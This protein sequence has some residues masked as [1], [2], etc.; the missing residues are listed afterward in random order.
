MHAAPESA[1]RAG[2]WCW[3]RS[4]ARTERLTRRVGPV[5]A[6]GIGCVPVVSISEDEDTVIAW[7]I[8]PASGGG[9]QG[10]SL[11]PAMRK[12]WRAAGVALPRTL[13]VLWT[14]V[15][16]AVRQLPVVVPLD[17]CRRTPGFVD[18]GSLVEGPSFGLAFCVHLASVVL[19]CA[20]PEHV[21]AA[22]AVDESG[23]VKPVGGLG[24][25]IAGVTMLLPR[26]TD[27]LVSAEQ[28]DEARHAAGGRV[29]IIGVA[30]AADAIEF[31]LGDTLS[32]LLVDAGY[33][34]DRR[35]GLTASFFRLALV[36]SDTIVDWGPVARGA[37]LAI[38]RWP[39][40]GPDAGYRLAFAHAVAA[41]H[42]SNRGRV[43][44]PPS[45]WFA[46][47]PRMLR[48][49]V[50]AH[51]VQQSADTATP[52]AAEIEARAVV[53]LT[54]RIEDAALQEL[55]LR[56]A[57]GRLR[58]VTGRA[59]QA[60]DDQRT[61]AEAFAALYAEDDV[62]RPLSEWSRLA[63]AL[64]DEASLAAACALHEQLLGRGGYGGLGARYVELAMTRARLM[65]DPS[66][67]DAR[68]SGRALC[69]DRS[70]P[71]HVRWSAHRCVADDDARHALQ[72]AADG[73]DALASRYRVLLDL[74]DANTSGDVEAA[75]AAVI[76]LG[77]YDPGPVTHLRRSGASVS[78]V[79]LLYPY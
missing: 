3:P 20:A 59:E 70:L 51:L 54:A 25:K 68:A 53:E 41:R 23:A 52:D 9:A 15:R 32:R 27:V 5:P 7:R 12:S 14:S 58:A 30:R 38:D 1:L 13:P 10:V 34:A 56:G 26:V 39:A 21:L 62:A 2:P 36:G 65:L 74:D 17:G 73:G 47:L 67:E 64:G 66:D 31:A 45:E 49:Q 48:L 77:L 71:D 24:R 72:V 50:L 6:I 19:G 57:I 78:D 4:E 60:H 46:T 33:D 29:R 55:R 18:P 61:I 28:V 44:M 22:A 35:E 75:E 8:S 16:D 11:G 40:G 43:H 42:E 69:D 63:G 76:A 37:A 79:A